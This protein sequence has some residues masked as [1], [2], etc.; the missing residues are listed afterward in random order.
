[1]GSSASVWMTLAIAAS[2]PAIALIWAV[3]WLELSPP[4]W[5]AALRKLLYLPLLLPGVL[6]VVGIHRLALAGGL[7]GTW[8]GVLL[9]HLLAVLPYTLIALS[10][11]YQGFD[12][13]YAHISAALGK[14]RWVY[15]L[16]VK[17]PLLRQSLW[18]TAAVGFAVSVAQFLPTLYI[19][20]GRIVTVT[21]EA[22]TLS[23]GGQRSL[24]AAFAWL[25][26]L[27]PAMAFALAA[28]LGKPRRWLNS[29]A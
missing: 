14:S 5:D 15:L 23:S 16:Q 22:V 17:W 21:T 3:A 2:S 4:S 26:W 8:L 27:L 12:A 19:G 29:K 6:W 10:P 24:V 25:Q 18:S 11:A 9:A 7:T 1:M 28:W 13:R 20:E